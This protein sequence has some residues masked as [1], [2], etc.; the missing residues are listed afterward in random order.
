MVV[1]F[2]HLWLRRFARGPVE[3]LWNSS[4]RALTRR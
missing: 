2:A 3:W 4:Y 1:T